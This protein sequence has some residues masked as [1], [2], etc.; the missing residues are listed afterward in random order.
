M[1]AVIFANGE[2][3]QTPRLVELANQADLVVAADGG[4]HNAF[5]LGVQPDI[6]IGDLD[7]LD[8]TLR[9]HLM[10]QGVQLL[11]FPC[12]KDE[13]DLELAID[14][15]VKE[16]ANVIHII[17][18][19]GGRIDQTAASLAILADPR[20][21]GRDIKLVDGIDTV[22]LIRYKTVLEG[23]IGDRVSLLAVG[24]D[25]HGV[26]TRG[27]KWSLQ[28]ETLY[29]HQ[30]R[31]ISNE[32]VSDQATIQVSQGMLLCIHSHMANLPFNTGGKS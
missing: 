13:T 32:L 19:L 15:V 4:A 25:A 24:G 20:L 31:G 8:S 6:V 23:S 3:N 22:R 28:E 1:K 21:D 27:L 29:F 9:E 17:G 12:D 18:G 7:S 10:S 5:D 26:S 16:N 11:P 30:A 14:Y 2:M